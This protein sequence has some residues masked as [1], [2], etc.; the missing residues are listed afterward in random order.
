[1]VK[2]LRQG[3]TAIALAVVL[4]SAAP[5]LAATC[6]N[7]TFPDSV[8]AGNAELLLNG[9]GLR[10][11]T[12]F[13]VK[14]YVA[15]LYL[16]QKSSDA[17]QILAANRPWR[18]EL[19]FVRDVGVSDIRNALE[20]HDAPTAMRIAHSIKG[21]SANLGANPLAEAAAKAESAIDSNTDVDAALVSLSALLDLTVA[22]IRSAL[23]SD[24]VGAPASNGDPSTVVASLSRL[25]KLLAADDGEASDFLLELRPALANI[26]TPA[27]L[28][29]LSTHVGNFAYS[30]ALQSLTSIASRLSLN[31]D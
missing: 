31:L 6:Q 15:G 26:L 23:P 9:L 20:A 8:K 17:G 5:A 7:V 14:V 27:E 24:S 2:F 11:A 1:M 18:L 4:V 3:S 25:K 22:S 19:R 10:K 13:N 12:M 16:P 28:D 30:D 29:S 21:A